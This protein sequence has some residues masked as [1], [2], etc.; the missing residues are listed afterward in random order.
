MRKNLKKFVTVCVCLAMVFVLIAGVLMW[1]KFTLADDSGA[2]ATEQGAEEGYVIADCLKGGGIFLEPNA[3]FVLEEGAEISGNSNAY[4]GGVYV[5]AGATFTMAGGTISDN[6][7]KF[8]GAIYVEA[9]GTVELLSGTISNNATEQNGTIF[10]EGGATLTMTTDNGQPQTVVASNSGAVSVASITNGSGVTMS[11]NYQ[12]LYDYDIDFYVGDT[13]KSVKVLADRKN[14]ASLASNLEFEFDPSEAPLNYEECCGYFLDK[15]FRHP[16]GTI[17][18]DMFDEFGGL[19]LFT[20]RATLDKLSFDNQMASVSAKDSSVSG[21]VVIPRMHNDK[22]VA[23]VGGFESC[24]ITSITLPATVEEIYSGAFDQCGNL[25]KCNITTGVRVIGSGAFNQN[26]AMSSV[27]LWEGNNVSFIG[28]VAFCG[29]A[30]QSEAY[31]YAN[32]IRLD[33][34]SSDFGT[35]VISE[36]VNKI[37]NYA[38]GGANI[39]NLIFESGSSPL[40]FGTDAFSNATITNLSIASVENWCKSTFE[41]SSANPI[42]FADNVFF[43]DSPYPTKSI[44]ISDVS[45]INQYAFYGL[46]QEFDSIT[47]DGVGVIGINAFSSSVG[48]IESV[49]IKNVTTIG[50]SAFAGSNIG[51]LALSDISTI[52]RKVFQKTTLSSVSFGANIG[53]VYAYAFDTKTKYQLKIPTLET[54]LNTN[55]V[56]S[57]NDGNNGVQNASVMRSASEL[58]IGG[59]KVTATL[60]LTVEQS[61]KVANS[62]HL[63]NAPISINLK[64][65]TEL[66]TATTGAATFGAKSV[67]LGT[68]PINKLSIENTSVSKYFYG[69]KDIKDV[70]FCDL[71]ET[72]SLPGTIIPDQAFLGSGITSLVIGDHITTIQGFAFSN[73]ASLQ[74]IT[75][76][77]SKNMKLTRIEGSCFNNTSVSGYSLESLNIADENAWC[78]IQFGSELANPMSYA[79]QVY[80]GGQTKSRLEL[81]T[82]NLYTFAFMYLKNLNYLS[83]R[84]PEGETQIKIFAKSVFGCSSLMSTYVGNGTTTGEG[85]EFLSSSDGDNSVFHGCFTNMKIYCSFAADSACQGNP[86]SSTEHDNLGGKTRYW[87]LIKREYVGTV[88][89]TFFEPTYSQTYDSWKQTFGIS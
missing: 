45:K 37:A 20:K 75:I 87:W 46:K 26:T 21:D 83:I 30:G 55:I 6:K 68:T 89:E 32:E 8:G 44:T 4:G 58:L 41:G 9:G 13:L 86:I 39:E 74:K 3:E 31:V 53:S 18:E 27:L 11:G 50:E 2:T 10:V 48:K 59:K 56:Y 57:N 7:A 64:I 61:T 84:P 40:E 15:E 16:V 22:D 36:N 43:Q 63:F 77:N 65:A 54:Y 72:S 60:D 66:S 62:F 78:N 73:C 19:K 28:E 42:A 81:R 38:F 34:F 88:Y 5:S 51:S 1:Q 29:C 24:D 12:E 17:T 52:D 14:D 80:F 82:S 67:Y 85:I 79:K 71:E 35:V 70:E 33:T 23:F 69:I 49:S 25:R 76:G 47:I